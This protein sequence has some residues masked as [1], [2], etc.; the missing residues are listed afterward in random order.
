M[1]NLSKQS[2][3]LFGLLNSFVS[4][5]AVEL[6]P[7]PKG[8]VVE[9]VVD[10]LGK[11]RRPVSSE[12]HLLKDLS[13]LNQIWKLEKGESYTT[14]VIQGGHLIYAHSQNDKLKVECLNNETGESI[15]QYTHELDY[16]DSYGYG[17]GPR[18]SAL[19]HEEKVYLHDVAGSLLCLDFESGEKIWTVN[20]SRFY[21]V[22]QAFFGVVST[23]LIEGDLIIVNV[24][25]P[26]GP[27]VV[28]FN[29]NNG[30]QQWTNGSKWMA[31]YASPIA[32]T[33]HGKRRVLVYAGGK[34]RPPVGGLICLD[35]KSGKIDFEFPWRSKTFESVNASTP[36][37]FD[38]KVFITATYETG[39]V[40]LEIQPDFSH[41]TLWTTK[42]L[43]CHWNTP[44]YENGYLYGFHGRHSRTA[45]LVCLDTKSGN[46]VWEETIR[47]KEK[48]PGSD[49]NY[50]FG[51]QLGSLLKVDGQYLC[52]SELGHLLWMNLSP[53]GV[54]ITSKQRLFIAKQTWCSPVIS[55]G[56]LYVSQN[57]RDKITGDRPSLRCY[58]LRA[59]SL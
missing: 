19:I 9:D 6:K 35:P 46:K 3:I 42:A 58:D 5:K 11:H 12:T 24:G 37:I 44:I 38:N 52:L 34:T 36:V 29:K 53:R 25:A 28:A 23:P 22:P 54:E 49:H 26:G 15:W 18:G 16:N 56:L 50:T 32:A 27:C 31:S 45:T 33:I 13:K 41:K 14:P 1:V 21:K 43:N 39:G 51:L 10:F 48:L 7:L 2:L 59:P 17:N 20:T 47:W 4:L 8:A 55:Q 57:E 30:R 40:L